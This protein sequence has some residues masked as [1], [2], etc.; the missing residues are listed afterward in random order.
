M[1]LIEVHILAFLPSN[2]EEAHTARA[3]STRARTCSLGCLRHQAVGSQ[4]V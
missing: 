3:A 2:A 1:C 4:L